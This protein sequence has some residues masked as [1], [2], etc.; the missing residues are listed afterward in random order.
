ML[1]GYLI[2]TEYE[3]RRNDF[4]IKKLISSANR[5][6]IDLSLLLFEKLKYFSDSIYYDEKKIIKPDFIIER[7]MN[8]HLSLSF[9]SMGIRV[10]NSSKVSAIS[11][12]KYLTYL[13][14]K[15]YG[16]PV[17]NTILQ[18]DITCE[19]VFYPNVTKPI[20]SK[21]GDRVFLN[22]N[23]DDYKK[24]IKSYNDTSFILQNVA[25]EVGK[26]LR[27]YVIGKEIIASVLRTSKTGFISNFC[28]GNDASLYTLK[29]SEIS[30]VKR[31]VNLIDADYVGI[32]FLFD[33]GN[34]VLNEIENVVGARMLYSLTD[35]N[36]ADRFIKYIIEK[37]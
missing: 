29:S 10:F 12:N 25:S 31:I 32:D 26:D 20:D 16:I 7:V 8:Y 6:N 11:D 34:L 28:K 14:M 36:I 4:F 33:K 30:L 35:I 1:K 19:N 21:G 3:S 2:Y 37:M 24:N 9:E 17:L 22:K 27:V 5:Y 15:T 18:Q 23:Y 13:N